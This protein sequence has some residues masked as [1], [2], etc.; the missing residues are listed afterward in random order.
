MLWLLEPTTGRGAPAP[1]GSRQMGTDSRVS[2]TETD[3]RGFT[4]VVYGNPLIEVTLLPE[5]GAK[6]IGPKDLRSNHE[7]L[8]TP[9]RPV[10]RLNNPADSWQEYDMSGCARAGP[11]PAPARERRAKEADALGQLAVTNGRTNGNG[12]LDWHFTGIL[13]EYLG[14]WPD[15]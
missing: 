9:A 11:A 14:D 13:D 6:V 2:I 3:H 1:R 8:T 7:W 10:R 5:V 15:N 12:K 4:A